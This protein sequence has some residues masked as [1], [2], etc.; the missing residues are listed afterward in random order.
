M[1]E[2]HAILIDNLTQVL[3]LAR[4][5]AKAINLALDCLEHGDSAGAQALLSEAL[6]RGKASAGH[7]LIA[8]G[9]AEDGR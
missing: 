1:A 5:Y 6:Q 9:Q 2:S 7:V 3:A 8:P 4:D